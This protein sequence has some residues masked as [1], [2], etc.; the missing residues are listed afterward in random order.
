MPFSVRARSTSSSW[1][2]VNNQSRMSLG[3]MLVAWAILESSMNAEV[4]EMC[5]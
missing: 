4:L 3:E 5:A 1:S 2:R